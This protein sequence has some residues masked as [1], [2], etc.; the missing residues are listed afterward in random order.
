MFTTN[1]TYVD[2]QRQYSNIKN[3]LNKLRKSDSF[4]PD[5]PIY[6]NLLKNLN[7]IEDEIEEFEIERRLNAL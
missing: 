3:E 7:Y 5:D 6:L 4:R 1:T 2:L